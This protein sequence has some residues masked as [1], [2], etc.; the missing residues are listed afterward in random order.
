MPSP[1]RAPSGGCRAPLAGR[2]SRT[3]ALPICAPPRQWRA[4]RRSCIR[5]AVPLPN[6][7]IPA[8]GSL[9]DGSARRCTSREQAAPF[10]AAAAPP[11]AATAPPVAVAVA[12][13]PATAP[14]PLPPAPPAAT[15]PPAPPPAVAAATPPPAATAN[16]QKTQ[17]QIG[18]K[19]LSLGDRVVLQKGITNYKC[20][21]TLV[22]GKVG[23]IGKID[24][25]DKKLPVF[26]KCNGVDK[27]E[28]TGAW[29]N[30]K[31]LLPA[32]PMI[33]PGTVK[34]GGKP[35][36]QQKL[37]AIFD[38]ESNSDTKTYCDTVLTLLLIDMKRNMY[39]FDANKFLK[40][41]GTTLGD[42]KPCPIV[43][44]ILKIIL[45]EGMKQVIDSNAYIFSPQK[46]FDYTED[47]FQNLEQRYAETFDDSEKEAFENM[48][49]IRYYNRTP[50]QFRDLLGDSP[51]ILSGHS[52][53]AEPEL[54]GVDVDGLY[55]EPL[56]MTADEKNLLT[57]RGIPLGA[58]IFMYITAVANNTHSDLLKSLQSEPL[59]E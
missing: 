23:T 39:D 37:Q 8:N 25:E 2:R 40:K 22:Y 49:P 41:I 44:H 20:L 1:H 18:D 33:R 26:V 42:T 7:R 35:T 28:I 56:R 24:L 55:D 31:D 57:C 43:F 16:P 15:A 51:Y 50:E 11:P 58:I 21:G 10:A 13:P 52:E 30:P 27:T 38:I 14:P 17:I 47:T 34:G 32:P 6:T 19:L 48:T 9:A 59:L 3:E 45:D 54:R 29:Y 53:E 5:G 12:P 4:R 36:P 46:P